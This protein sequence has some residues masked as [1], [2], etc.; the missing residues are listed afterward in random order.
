MAPGNDTSLYFVATGGEPKAHNGSGENPAIVLLAV[1]GNKPPEKVTI[2]EF[3]TVASV[4]TNLRPSPRRYVAR[5][6]LEL[7]MVEWPSWLKAAVL[8]STR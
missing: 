2:N 8:K 6:T 1:L 3:T 7:S 5:N 4:W